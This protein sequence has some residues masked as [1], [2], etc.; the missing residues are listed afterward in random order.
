MSALSIDYREAGLEDVDAIAQVNSDTMRECGLAPPDLHD[1]QRLRTRWDGYVRRVRHPQHALESRILFAA[2]VD[3]R[4]V[5]YVAGHFSQRHGTEGELQ[6]IYVLKEY[7]G[8]GIGAALLKRLAEWFVGNKRLSVC[9]GIDPFNPYKK[10]YEKH[11]ARYI[12]QHWLA[13]D[14]IG[15]VL[16]G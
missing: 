12:N 6:S 15:S 3:G 13:W 1:V 4:L 11:G 9:V 14:D 5:G 10:F 16:K 7:Q 2:V 8:R